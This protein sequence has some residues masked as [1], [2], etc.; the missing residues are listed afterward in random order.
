[1]SA[2]IA[3]LLHERRPGFTLPQAFYV[4]PVVFDLDMAA[5]FHRHWLFAAAACEIAAPGDFVTL[6][7]GHAS[8]IVLRDREGEVRAFHNVCRHRGSRLCE[9]ERG[10]TGALVCPYH[11]WTY[12][13]DGRLTY[14]RYMGEEL[15]PAAHGLRAV[16]VQVAAGTIYVC[17]AE[18]PP[19]FAPHAAALARQLGPHALERARLAA[20][21]HMIEDGNWKLVMENS[22]ECYHCAT[23][24]RE[25]MRSLL[26]IYDFNDLGSAA[27]IRAY[28]AQCEAAGLPSGVDEGP[29]FRVNRLPF[30]NTAQSMTMDGRMAVA[31]PLGRTPADAFGS[32]RWVHYPSTFNHALNDYAVLVR[33]LP[34]AP[35]QT[36]VTMKFLVD[37][38]AIEGVDYSLERLTEVWN[39][40]NAQDKA[41]VERNQRGVR[42][43][44]Y[45]PGPYSRQLEAGVIKFVDW[46]AARIGAWLGES[47]GQPA[48]IDDEV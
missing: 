8:F 46:Y 4:D 26:D 10:N 17:L 40:T 1:M 20:E 15:D 13:L 23:G 33:M 42:S 30:V 27:E 2:D 37:A 35:Q 18:E 9:T 16:H 32:L 34:I 21:I 11:K 28:W 48:A 41:L 19:D 29:D 12:A 31:R 3:A 38:D 22:R 5:I 47:G 36:L 44:G 45:V 7:I 14:A 24:H 39:V 43:P 6:E 25:L